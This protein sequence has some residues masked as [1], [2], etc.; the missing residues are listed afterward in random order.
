MRISDWS[1][2]VCSSDLQH[3]AATKQVRLE[4]KRSSYTSGANNPNAQAAAA[5]L[6]SA[7]ASAITRV[8]TDATGGAGFNS[9]TELGYAQDIANV[10]TA[11]DFRLSSDQAAELF[12]E[13][14]SAAI[15]GSLD[16]EIGRR[17]GRGT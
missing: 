17:S 3:D 9:V 7:L 11:L 10:A 5:G 4:V 1:S 2:D 12:H 8:R 15:I 6:D 16:A 13:M 14:S